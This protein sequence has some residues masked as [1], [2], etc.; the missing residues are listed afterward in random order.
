MKWLV[1]D[2]ERLSR[3]SLIYSIKELVK[4]PGLEIL[5]ADCVPDA[6]KK[7][8]EEKPELVFLDI[9]MPGEKGL[10]LIGHFER[11]DFDIIFVTAYH[12]YALEAF[13]Q[14]AVDYLLK[15]IDD[16]ELKKALIKFK[17]TRSTKSKAR[18]YSLLRDLLRG[19]R[20]KNLAIPTQHG[21]EVTPYS[22]IVKIESSGS[23]SI[24]HL[25]KRK[26]TVSRNLKYFEKI[27]PAMSFF[28]IHDSFI[29]NK[30]HIYKYV[31]GAGGHVVLSDGSTLTVS[32]RRR[33]AFLKGMGVI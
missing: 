23:Y 19:Y 6:L 25:G 4:S 7:I 13:R 16:R 29:I 28:R 31:R 21:F 15:P 11:V 30:D 2:D 24:I 8:E 10:D 33:E 17:R 27:L 5:E 22:E 26:V 20:D 9:E 32:K 1:V 3:V 14:N 12:N 18:S